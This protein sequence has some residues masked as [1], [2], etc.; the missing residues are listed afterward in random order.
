MLVDRVANVELAQRTAGYA[1][2][3]LR[4][5]TRQAEARGESPISPDRLMDLIVAPIVYRL[6]FV[7]QAIDPAYRK[8]LVAA[9]LARPEP[10]I[11][12]GQP[13]FAQYVIF[14]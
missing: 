2:S 12:T 6:I 8:A 9:A 11:H 5:F 10:E 14:E 1:Y 7:G 3:N 13:S 4:T